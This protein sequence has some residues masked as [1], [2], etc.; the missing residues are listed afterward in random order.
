MGVIG[1]PSSLGWEKVP[2]PV[3]DRGYYI[4]SWGTPTWGWGMPQEKY[5]GPVEALWDGDGVLSKKGMGQVEVLCDGDGVNLP[6]QRDMRP[7]VGSV[8]GW[9]WSAPPP[10]GQTDIPKYKHYPSLVLRTRA[11]K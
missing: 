4:L 1:T 11:V 6:L 9:R 8:I 5:M 3:L 2:H 10:F 7:V